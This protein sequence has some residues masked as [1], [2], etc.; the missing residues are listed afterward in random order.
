[1]KLPKIARRREAGSSLVE[2]SLALVILGVG[3]LAMLAVQISALH[4]SRWGRHTTDAAQI[5]RDQM[6]QI[7]R[8]PFADP[9]VADTGGWTLPLALNQ[10]VTSAAGASIEQT[11]NL[12]WRITDSPVDPNI[13]AVDVRV[14]WFEANQNPG[15]PPRRYAMTSLKFSE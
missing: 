9:A 12:Q 1:M 3:L 13:K 7:L 8:I 5:A 10:T 14:N 2:T 6:E 4:Q 11:F 15:A